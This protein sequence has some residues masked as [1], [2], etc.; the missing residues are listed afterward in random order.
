VDIASGAGDPAVATRLAARLAAAGIGVGT[1]TTTEAAT[2]AVQYPD[3]QGRQAGT[4]AAALGLGGSEQ[5]ARVAH[6]TVMI[7]ARDS[8]RLVG[9]QPLC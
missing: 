1:V 3:G 6:V 7:G 9:P 5:L 4:L 2:S 8:D